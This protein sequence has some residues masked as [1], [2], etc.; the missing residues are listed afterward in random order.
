MPAQEPIETLIHFVFPSAMSSGLPLI[1]DCLPT[2]QPRMISRRF[3]S[4]SVAAATVRLPRMLLYSRPE[5]GLCEEAKESISKAVKELPEFELQVVNILEPENKEWFDKYAFD[6]PVVHFQTS[7]SDK[8]HRIMH[9]IK[10]K[11]VID[12]VNNSLKESS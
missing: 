9:H 10:Q 8:I 4:R 2:V 12:L 1:I 6:V 3:F 5:C 11:D 7:E